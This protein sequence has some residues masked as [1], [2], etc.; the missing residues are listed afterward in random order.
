MTQIILEPLSK[1]LD[2]RLEQRA[3][4][5][6]YGGDGVIVSTN[7]NDFAADYVIC[8]V[9]LGVLKQKKITTV[10]ILFLTSISWF[11]RSYHI[12]SIGRD[13]KESSCPFYFF[14][15]VKCLGRIR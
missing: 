11:L 5:I 8:S 13:K 1:N 14:D 7:E 15:K 6:A 3:E 10:A 4:R 12:S 2:I 9:P